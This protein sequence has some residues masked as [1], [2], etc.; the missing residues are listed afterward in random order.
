MARKRT[1]V[2]SKPKGTVAQARA[3][4]KRPAAGRH[5]ESFKSLIALVAIFLGIRAFI[6]EAYRIPSGSMEPSLLIGD[7]LFVNKFIYGPTIPFTNSPIRI[8]IPG[9]PLRL[10]R[11]PR[12]GDIVVFRSPPQRDQPTDST[13][14]LVKRVIGMPGD[15]IYMRKGLVYVNGMPQRQGYGAHAEPTPDQ[16]SAYDRLFDWQHE[17]ELRGSRFG[18]PPER[19]T[20]DDWGPLRI[21]ENRYMMLG[22][23]RYDSKDSRYW[24]FV[25]RNNVRGQPIFVY[26]SFDKECGS[27]VCFLTDIRWNRIG[28]LIR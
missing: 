7:W 8:R 11:D 27:G 18:A 20:H 14:T 1:P 25:P 10:Y 15:T 2:S 6:I 12:R 5:W 17:F 21:P 4:G 23:N 28:H 26:Y 19:P 13:P 22:D 9:T 16:T 24:G 3:G